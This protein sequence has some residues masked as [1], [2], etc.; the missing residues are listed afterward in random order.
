MYLFTARVFR[1][2]RCPV[3]GQRLNRGDLS[4]SVAGLDRVLYTRVWGE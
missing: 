1:A 2:T 4:V 3:C